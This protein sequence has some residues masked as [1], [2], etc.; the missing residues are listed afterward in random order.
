[1]LSVDA[2]TRDT[3]LTVASRTPCT[4]GGYGYGGCVNVANG[5]PARDKV[6]PLKNADTFALFGLGTVHPLRNSGAMAWSVHVNQP[7]S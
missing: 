3:T 2:Q 6:G 7:L 1:M 5:K 4:D